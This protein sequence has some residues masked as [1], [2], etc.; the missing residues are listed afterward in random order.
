MR[1]A[2]RRFSRRQKR[3]MALRARFQC[4]LCGTDT[5]IS[6]A[7][8]DHIIPYSRDGA[9]TLGNGQYLCA[10]CNLRKGAKM[11]GGLLKWQAEALKKYENSLA[12]GRDVFLA[13]ACT[14][15]GKTRF[16]IEAARRAY[17]RA[18]AEDVIVVVCP[19][20]AISMGWARG[21][22]RAGLLAVTS[23]NYVDNTC[24][25][26]VMTYSALAAHGGLV[27]EWLKSERRQPIVVL[28]EIHHVAELAPGRESGWG[29]AVTAALSGIARNIIALTATPYRSKGRIALL[30]S[31]YTEAQGGSVITDPDFSHRYID[32]LNAID[33]PKSGI[34]RNVTPCAFTLRH[35]SAEVK[36]R[37]SDSRRVLQAFEVHTKDAHSLDEH[38]RPCGHKECN[39]SSMLSR[40]VPLGAPGEMESPAL[41]VIRSMLYEAGAAL[42]RM[43]SE[44]GMWWAGGLV[45]CA[46]K[47]AARNVRQWIEDNIGKADL[48]THDVSEAQ[49]LIDEFKRG[50]TKHGPAWIVSVD[51][52]SEGVDISRLKVLV[53]IGTKQTQLR[54]I[55][56]IGRVIRRHRNRQ[57]LPY[58]GPQTAHVYALNV[59]AWRYVAMKFEEDI[60]QAT[61]AQLDSI[62]EALEREA[63]TSTL[64]VSATHSEGSTVIIHGE[65]YEDERVGELAQR[66]IAMDFDGLR[67]ARHGYQTALKLA[68]HMVRTNTAPPELE[69]GPGDDRAQDCEIKTT[70]EQKRALRK[71]GEAM[72]K[73]LTRA[74]M[75]AWPKSNPE[76]RQTK[77]TLTMLINKAAGCKSAKEATKAELE[78]R[79]EEVKKALSDPYLI[80][81]LREARNG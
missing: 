31:Y 37:C 28:D 19:T 49:L 39:E 67:A 76:F 77:L 12:D 62:S 21:L 69:H 14:G 68:A 11:P 23:F 64:E 78:K 59:P 70:E 58:P 24:D 10:S 40:Y 22:E 72:L 26:L 66:L 27:R 44:E 38:G 29:E 71:Q 53:S 80:E 18:W 51:M 15:S 74:Y 65:A 57:G 46:N 45:I 56:E 16:G 32:E 35:A 41:D 73:R 5:P 81:A 61:V 13:V 79:I 1:D 6:K 54:I 17:H 9:T 34:Y 42:K 36:R 75:D 52:V 47:D 25:A 7:H 60:K 55:Q 33:D 8:A 30:D 48:V 63:P 4:E 50:G 20:K 2:R 43:R 3:T